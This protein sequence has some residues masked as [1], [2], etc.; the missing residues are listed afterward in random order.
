MDILGVRAQASGTG[1]EMHIT[2]SAFPLSSIAESSGS[3]QDSRIFCFLQPKPVVVKLE[4]GLPGP[5]PTFLPPGAPCCTQGTL[6]RS[7]E[8]I[9]H[10]GC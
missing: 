5:L 8:R 1:W 4:R 3:L 10:S 6:T 2:Q 7:S 9:F